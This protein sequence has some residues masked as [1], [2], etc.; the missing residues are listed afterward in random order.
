MLNCQTLRPQPQNDVAAGRCWRGLSAAERG[1]MDAAEALMS[2]SCR[3]KAAGRRCA[4]VRPLTPS[5]DVWEEAEDP[6]LASPV[7]DSQTSPFCMTPP[8][9]PPTFDVAPPPARASPV[10]EP[11]KSPAE[12]PRAGV[13]PAGQPRSRA[14]SVI[15]HTADVQPRAPPLLSENAAPAGPP[16]G[17]GPGAAPAVAAVGVSPVPV[18]CQVLPV[19]SPA[20]PLVATIVPAAAA[21]SSPVARPTAVCQP[22]VFMGTQA[23]KGP[24]MLLV[25]RPAAPARPPARGSPGGAR[26]APIAPAPGF[27]PAVHRAAP[28]ADAPRVRSHSCCHPGCGKTYFKS[29]HLKAHMRTHTGEKPFCCSWEGCERRFA[30]SDELSRHRRTHTGEKRFAC[31]LCDSRFMR[32][33]HLTKHARRHLASRKLPGWQVEIGQLKDFA[34]APV[35][36][37]T[38]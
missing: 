13:V 17:S 12:E 6:L 35:P 19:P 37:S 23:P 11:G 18:V 33:D 3:W 36:R 2:M 4:D 25:P 22:L 24:V 16:Q 32:S 31:P 1:D 29:S 20:S 9:S 10:P 30:R 15:R 27:A 8:Y 7:D 26:L 21:A 5:S 38:P 34:A 28:Q 14:T